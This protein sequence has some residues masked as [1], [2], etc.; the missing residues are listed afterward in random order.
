[1]ADPFQRVAAIQATTVQLA[2]GLPDQTQ[3]LFRTHA[4]FGEGVSVAKS[5]VFGSTFIVAVALIVARKTARSISEEP[6]SPLDEQ[7]ARTKHEQE[8]Q[9]LI[10]D[11]RNADRQLCELDLRLKWQAIEERKLVL[12]QRKDKHEKRE[13]ASELT[14]DPSI[15]PL[16]ELECE[17]KRNIMIDMWPEHEEVIS[18]MNPTERE[19]LLAVV[20]RKTSPRL[21]VVTICDGDLVESTPRAD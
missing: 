17:C 7:R 10:H 19:G 12:K 1:M 3:T 21:Q 2:K 16:E 6:I 13:I 11:H 8:M 5:I 15:Q 14:R 20:G 4:M 18:K 9:H